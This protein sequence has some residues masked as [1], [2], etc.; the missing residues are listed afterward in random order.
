ML[1]CRYEFQCQYG[2]IGWAVGATL[3][4][5]VRHCHASYYLLCCKTHQAACGSE[6]SAAPKA[7]MLDCKHVKA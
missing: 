3:G 4:Y 5:S 6:I 7:A 1:T 2:S